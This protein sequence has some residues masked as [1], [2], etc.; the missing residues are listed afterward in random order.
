[1]TGE[2]VGIGYGSNKKCFIK[3]FNK[4][5][6]IIQDFRLSLSKKKDIEDE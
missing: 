6:D 5:V 2:L 3:K 1:M 4:M